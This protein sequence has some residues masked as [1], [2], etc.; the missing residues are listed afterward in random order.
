MMEELNIMKT[1]TNKIS[2][3]I[4]GF[5]YIEG[6]MLNIYLDDFKAVLNKELKKNG[7]EAFYALKAVGYYKGREYPQEIITV[8]FDKEDV[9]GCFARTVYSMRDSLK[10]EAYA[11]ELNGAMYIYKA[12]EFYSLISK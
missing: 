6:K 3:H 2:F 10:Q 8:F 12:E 5:K 1:L 4:P 7:I 11:Y 9:L